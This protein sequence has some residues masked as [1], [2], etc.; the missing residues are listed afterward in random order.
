MG[1]FM[2]STKTYHNPNNEVSFNTKLLSYQWI[3]KHHSIMKYHSK[4]S[5]H[6]I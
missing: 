1:Y 4:R 5:Y 6:W 2:I 3:L